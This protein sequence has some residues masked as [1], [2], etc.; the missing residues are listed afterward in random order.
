MF[1]WLVLIILF[2]STNPVDKPKERQNYVWSYQKQNAKEPEPPPSSDP[3]LPRVCPRS[4][5]FI[6]DENRRIIGRK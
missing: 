5:H 4:K 1:W 2:A 3:S 6:L